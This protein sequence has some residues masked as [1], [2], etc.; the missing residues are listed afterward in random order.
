VREEGEIQNGSVR[1]KDFKVAQRFNAVTYWNHD[2]APSSTDWLPKAMQWQTDGPV[3]H[4]QVTDAEFAAAE[5][6]MAQ[7]RAASGATTS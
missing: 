5:A 3:L 6:A 7:R 1:A 2:T 4:G